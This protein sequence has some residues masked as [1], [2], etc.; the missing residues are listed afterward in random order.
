M[1]TVTVS[2]KP[3]ATLPLPSRAVTRTAG[4][5]VAP[6][7]VLLGCTVNCSR[8]AAPGVM[9]N[10]ELVPGGSDPDVAVRV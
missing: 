9:S 8:V 5:I 7:A 4:V 10:T 2:V 3:V 6:A 1:A